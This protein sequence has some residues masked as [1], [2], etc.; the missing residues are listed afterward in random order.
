MHICSTGDIIEAH[1]SLVNSS[2]NPFMVENRPIGQLVI[3]VVS[4]RTL[5]AFLVNY[6]YKFSNRW[7][8]MD[9]DSGLFFGILNGT[10]SMHSSLNSVSYD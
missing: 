10:S 8:N 3:A 4:C 9:G 6:Y 7:S 2:E 1:E 5:K